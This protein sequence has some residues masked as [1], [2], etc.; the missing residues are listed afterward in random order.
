MCLLPVL[1]IAYISTPTRT[2]TNTARAKHTS[3][4]TFLQLAAIIPIYG[5]KDTEH[6]KSEAIQIR[7]NIKTYHNSQIYVIFRLAAIW[8]QRYDT[9]HIHTLKRTRANID[10]ITRYYIMYAYKDYICTLFAPYIYNL[11][12]IIAHFS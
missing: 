10:Y 7:H 9:Y 2:H 3:T 5:Y 4:K 12:P 8:L 1:N 11:H 6:G